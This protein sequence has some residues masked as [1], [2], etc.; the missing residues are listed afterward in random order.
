MQRFRYINEITNYAVTPILTLQFV[1]GTSPVTKTDGLFVSS[2]RVEQRGKTGRAKNPN[3]SKTFSWGS[4][5][6]WWVLMGSNGSWWVLMGS[7]GFWWVLMGSDGFWWVLMG[8][9]GFWWVLMGSDD[10]FCFFYKKKQLQFTGLSASSVCH[11]CANDDYGSEDS[12]RRIVSQV[13]SALIWIAILTWILYVL[14]RLGMLL[15]RC[16]RNTA[17][18]P[19]SDLSQVEPKDGAWSGP[20]I[21]VE[22]VKCV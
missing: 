4:D 19:L 14:I 10:S 6:F 9:D 8:S 13:M 15:Y 3:I 17:C 18:C 21:Y 22:S 5:G 7:D 2:Y 16:C 20:W 1:K 11:C 12:N